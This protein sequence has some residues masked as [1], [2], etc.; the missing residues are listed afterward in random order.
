MKPVELEIIMRDS[1]RQGMQSVEGNVD[2]LNKQIE[3]QT[4]LI[5]KLETDLKTMQAAFEKASHSGDQT[6]NIAMI[7]ALRKEV[8][9]LKGA[10]ADLEKQQRQTSSA[11][12]ATP[13]APLGLKEQIAEVK[14]NIKYM[15]DYVKQYEKSMKG[16]A[17]GKEQ[18][19][20]RQE[21]EGARTALLAEKEALAGLEEQMGSAG[22]K[23]ATL[24]TQ[25]AQLKQE[26]SL[27]TEGT[28]EYQEAMKH[29]GELQ[30]QYGDIST[31][32]RIFSDDNKNIKAT[33]DAVSGLSGAMTAGV[34]VA[35]LFGMQEEKLAQIQTKLQAVMAI[36]M[37]VQQVANTLNKDSYFTH[38]LLAGAK[39]MLTVA[40]TRLAVSLGISNVAAK[41][42]M[43]TLTLGLSVVITGLI[44][45]WD[46]YRTVQNAATKAQEE[47]T[48]AAKKQAEAEG[49][50]RKSA[51][52]SV[53]AQLLEYKKLQ[54]AYQDLGDDV[55]KKKKFIDENKKS[56]EELGI[57]VRGVKDA[58]N[59]LIDGEEAFLRT[60]N[61]RALIAASMELAA[62]KYKEAIAK[63][64]EVDAKKKKAEG[65]TGKDLDADDLTLASRMAADEMHKK[66]GGNFLEGIS[67]ENMEENLKKY[68]Q[69]GNEFYVKVLEEF[70]RE[71]EKAI[72]TVTEQNKGALERNAEEERKNVE[73]FMNEGAE[74]LKN[75]TKLT[76]ENKDIFQRAGFVPFKKT[77]KNS[78]DKETKADEL[79][80]AE[81]K[82]RQKINNMTLSLM[83]EGEAKKKALA[84]KQFDDEL[85]RIDQEERERL[86]ALQAAQKNGMMVTPEQVATVK[87]Q[88]K[89]QRDL[90][91]EK[92]IKD[93]FTVEKEYADKS[94]KLKAEKI[95]AQ[96]EYD[97]EYGTY[98]EKRLAIEMEFNEKLAD[99]QTKRREAEKKGDTET[100]ALMDI[101]LAKTTKDKGKSLMSMDYEQLK[102][103]PEYIRAFENLKET[104][105]DTLNSL[106][107]QFEN[108][109]QTAAKVLSPDQLREYT[110]TIQS[111]MDELDK[112]NPFQSLSD[113]KKELAEAE[114]ELALAQTEL[115]N[116]RQTAEAVKGGA[117]IENGITSSKFNPKTGKI[118]ST[119]AYLTEAQA[120]EKVKDK[121]EKYNAAKDKVTKSDAKVKKSQKE[122]RDQV[123]ELCNTIDDLGKSI[124]GPAGEIISLIGNIGSF[125]LMAMDGV[126]AAA[127]TSANA[128]STVEK[129]SVILAIISAAIQIATKIASLFKDDD[130]VAEYERATKVYESYITILDKI[131]EKQK[132]LF[133]LNSKTGQQAYENAKEMVLKQED[134]SR[135]LGK[136]Y[137][138]SGASKGFLGMG[139]SSSKG[140]DQRKDISTK[141]WNE[142]KNALGR[143]FYNYNIG[144][145]R[146]T[147]LF[148][149]SAEQLSKLQKDAPL[150]WAEL[151][152]DTQKYL[153]QIID[154]NDEL[155]KLENDRKE[156]L[157]KTDFDSFLSSFTDMLTDMNSSS[158]DFADNFE[159]YL[160]NAILSS[161]ITDKY[162]DRI[163]ILYNNWAAATDSDEK[164]TAEEAEALRKEREAITEDMLKKRQELAD[165]F[166]WGSDSSSSQSGRA[167]ATTTVTEETA[168]KIE[169]IA[170]S[171]QIRIISMDDKM[172]DISQ[173]AY[174]AIGILSTIAENTVFCKRLADI[175]D[176]VEKIERDG[177]KIKG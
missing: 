85:A 45:L 89:Q 137:L 53:G 67:E 143:D 17:P 24:R 167:G 166:G 51:A 125:T 60:M 168:G 15:E 152:D 123:D 110:S 155:T 120:L 3:Q 78:F 81:L 29:L 135:E 75:G 84:R 79:A 34:G 61:N 118:E 68:A 97:K 70:N 100:V 103:S 128:I 59:L 22:Q 77:D 141:A 82:V 94:K 114:E 73:K 161:L 49:E 116:A 172:T 145:G 133:E 163:K 129:A 9:K 5:Q 104:S 57:S 150:F 43:A 46:K 40:N 4:S 52:G 147:G 19:A 158:K 111:I 56:F 113:K 171:I 39:N 124:G 88:A 38:V 65:Y 27:M 21:L 127:D 33:M 107:A 35:S 121:T 1:T 108:A 37:G 93:F 13:V 69:T 50:L 96:I 32:G 62:E 18:V 92:Y 117:K 132:E 64:M 10:L 25:I 153:Q 66:R 175:A 149:L 74:S 55:K 28:E 102:E 136:Q 98:Q 164:L 44:A 115:E 41:A 47:A 86:K 126:E 2:A 48:E 8:A 177:V 31:Q 7:A 134:A 174:D 131:I 148:D 87:D 142:A 144:D 130:G 14:A 106:L 109:K 157:V 140:V 139:S 95:Q 105:S 26:M 154:C 165:A 80:E 36:T 151:H 119:K 90:A 76:Q 112:R 72:E 173:Y 42:L 138:D 23:Q 30:D 54:N 6:E 11:P 160:K 83:E 101:A 12:V 71:K 169:G 162:R 176:V 58:E 170:T 20:M 156:G 16:M 91:G 122:V 146:M 159:E 63:M 99:I